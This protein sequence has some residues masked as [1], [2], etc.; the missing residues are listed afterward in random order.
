MSKVFGSFCSPHIN[1]NILLF[2][3]GLGRAKLVSPANWISEGYKQARPNGE[4]S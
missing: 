2:E 1:G 4:P 3:F